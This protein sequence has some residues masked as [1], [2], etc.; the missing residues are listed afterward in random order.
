MLGF[1]RNERGKGKAE[2]FHRLAC[3]EQISSAHKAFGMSKGELEEHK[4]CP[5]NF[6]L[7]CDLLAAI[8][9]QQKAKEAQNI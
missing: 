9:Q 7:G 6:Q 3:F 2:V 1:A 8:F 4:V 5:K